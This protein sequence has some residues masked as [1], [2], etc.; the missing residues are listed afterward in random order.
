MNFYSIAT[1]RI[2]TLLM[3]AGTL[4]VTGCASTILIPSG[5]SHVVQTSH[6]VA[7]GQGL[8]VMPQAKAAWEAGNTLEAERLYSLVAQDSRVPAS[9]RALGWERVARSAV[10]NNNAQRAFDALAQ[11]KTLVAG[12]ETQPTWLAL[13]R[14][15][16]A[17]SQGSAPAHPVAGQPQTTVAFNG[18]C[19]ALALP[20]SGPYAP[21]GAKISNGATAASTTLQASGTTMTVV[22]V[23][24]EAPDWLDKLAQLPPQCV[25]VGGPLR[26]EPYLAA[27]TRKL[28]SSKA[29]FSFMSSLEGNDE[30]TVAW[31]FFSSPEDQVAAVLRFTRQ[32]G[33]NSYGV[34]SPN[35]NYGQRMTELFMQAARSPEFG[36]SQVSVTNYQ[37]GDTSSWPSVMSAFVGGRMAGKVPVS[38]ATFQAVFIP[39]SWKNMERLVPYLFYQGEDRLV[40]MGTALWEQ[41]LSNRDRVNVT[42]LDLA[43]FPGAWNALTP[44][45]AATALISSLSLAGKGTPDFWEGIGYDFVRF[46]SAMN[47]Q[48]GWTA[49][50]VNKRI[51]VAQNIDWSMAP[52]NWANGHAAQQLFIFHPTESGSE[53]VN[54]QTFTERLTTIRARHAR[55]SAGTG[56]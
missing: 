41:G 13:W 25:T 4:L 31:R 11:W 26:P 14:A 40:L 30:G 22:V 15:A 42:N 17:L 38:S 52:I 51:L 44:S 19:V 23:D 16:S 32:I 24:T 5:Q 18:G 39:D 10:A 54:P 46:A 27:K 43:I 2:L 29:F 33:I 9:G 55:R 49:P 7:P 53:L 3:V 37:P 48:Q 34:L 36:G 35:E 28:L 50:D 21:F 12:V 20:M 47:L 8:A 6:T 56:K 45:P 1:R